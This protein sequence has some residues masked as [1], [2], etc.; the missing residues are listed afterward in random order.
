MGIISK[1]IMYQKGSS[2]ICQSLYD[3]LP[4]NQKQYWVMCVP[5]FDK[6]EKEFK[7]RLKTNDFIETEMS[8]EDM[9]SKDIDTGA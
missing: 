1:D 4:E 2:L 3:N 8:V 5:D 6:L 7:K 9:I